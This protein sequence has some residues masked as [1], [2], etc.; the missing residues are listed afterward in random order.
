M[1]IHT[2]VDNH[3]TIS[4]SQ[5]VAINKLSAGKTTDSRSNYSHKS[6]NH[7]LK[8]IFLRKLPVKNVYYIRN[9]VDHMEEITNVNVE[10]DSLVNSVKTSSD[11]INETD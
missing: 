2:S 6:I 11:L 9:S 7:N 1:C 5:S 3:N 8:T 10:N 4:L